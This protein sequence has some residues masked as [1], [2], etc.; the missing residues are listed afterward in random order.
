[1]EEPHKKAYDPTKEQMKEPIGL[2]EY[3]SSLGRVDP[4]S[5]NLPHQE[6]QQ[7]R[8]KAIELAL[9]RFGSSQASYASEEI[10]L[11]QAQRFYTYIT[12]GE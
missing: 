9:M 10:I 5:V 7:L 2:Q 8:A 11:K 4:I 3:V 6:N 1:M 12:E